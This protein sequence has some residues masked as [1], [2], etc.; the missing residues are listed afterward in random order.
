MKNFQC[1]FDDK[2]SK[3]KGTRFRCHRGIIIKIKNKGQLENK[4]TVN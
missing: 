3:K 2:M 1:L 4:L